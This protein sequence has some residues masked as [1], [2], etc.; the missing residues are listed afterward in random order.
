LTTRHLR[1]VRIA[2]YP[3]GFL[4]VLAFLLGF[5]GAC[6]APE[7]ASW[8]RF[9]FQQIQMG[10]LFR[11]VVWARDGTTATNAAVAAFQRVQALNTQ[12]S[13]YEEASE[14]SR[15]SQTSG[16]GQWVSVSDELWNVL[17]RGDA[18]SRASGGGF[19]VT[20][21]PL[22]QVWRRA[23]R[24]RE[25]PSPERIQ[26]AQASVGWQHLQFDERAKAV[27]LEVSD[28]RLDLGAIA[29]GYALDEVGRVMRAHGLPRFLVAGAGDMVA[30]DP[31]PGQ[32][33]WKVEVA[34]LDSPDAPPPRDISLRNAALCTS[35]D[36][37]QHLEI[38]G[39]RYSHI[40]D[41]RTGV[42]LT[43]HSLVTVIGRDGMT[44][45]ALATAVSVVGPERGL[46]LVRRFD[47]EVLVVRRPEGKLEEHS[48]RGFWRWMIRRDQN[49]KNP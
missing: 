22:I 33:G 12:L 35:G 24:Q 31:P 15:L 30:G 17:K 29:K 27:R 47:A 7:T 20:V 36:L 19:D 42:G 25:L 39:K 49:L 46:S 2:G 11:L 13:D 9:E 18:I 3:F 4:A 45:D 44:S 23:R 26:R 6:R 5:L 8:N 1:C 48:T 32:S 21:G 41:P 40:V 28:M 34:P 37:F 43:D 38:G 14:L 16:G 10:L